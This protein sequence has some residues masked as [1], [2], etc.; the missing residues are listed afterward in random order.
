M[1]K[2]KQDISKWV[3]S[4]TS[5]MFSY[6]FHRL[7]DE[8]LAR[9]IVQ[10]TFVTA[11]EKIKDFRGES[12]PKTWL[13]SILKYK[14]IEVYRKK[15]KTPLPADTSTLADFFDDSNSWSQNQRPMPWSN[16]D[17]HLL[18]DN[19]FKNVLKECLDALPAKWSS[20]VKLK[21]L[22]DKKGEEICQELDISPTNFWQI[23]HRAKLNLRDCL[24]KNWFQN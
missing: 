7:Y 11:A 19:D 22:M 9:D 17:L 23:M 14:I 2:Q 3:E 4:Y 8:D 12:T 16:E 5:A 18:D 10:D 6:A 13:F 24:E 15:A 20:T 21:Y 1:S